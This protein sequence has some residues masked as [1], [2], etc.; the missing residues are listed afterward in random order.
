MIMATKTQIFLEHLS[1]YRQAGKTQKG[2]ILRHICYVTGMH[3]KAAIRKFKRLQRRNR[4][5]PETRGRTTYYTTEVTTALKMLWQ[6]GNE[7][8]GELLHPLIAEYVSIFQRDGMWEYADDTTAKLQTMSLATLKRRIGRFLAARQGRKGIAT[9]KPSHLKCLVPILFGP[10][11]DKPPGYGQ[12]DTV[13]QSH[14]ASGDAVYTLN[15][16]DAATL[17]VTPRAQ[18]NRGQEATLNAM[19]VIRQKMPFRWQGAH[20]DTGSE[21]INQLVMAWCSEQGIELSRSRP[22]RKNDNMYVEER[23]GHVVRKT[24]G[25]LTLDCRQAVDALNELYEVLIPYLL[26]FVAVRRLVSKERVGSQYKRTYEKT[27][28]TPYQRICEYP[29]VSEEVKAR[30]Q[31][32]HKNL[33]PLLLKREIDQG[34]KKLYAV[35]RRYGTVQLF[36]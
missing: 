10:W 16:T 32:Q 36:R 2:E 30:L 33:N 8:C 9:T 27:A 17:M 22:N 14:S 35:Q 25:Y 20:P 18:W 7:V 26:H 19:R 31:Q 21:F 28:K 13:K 24:I 23:N 5:K 15:Y 11:Q 3:R 4:W 12:I 1:S 34:R 6:A 29:S